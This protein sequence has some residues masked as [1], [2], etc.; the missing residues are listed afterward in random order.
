MMRVLWCA[1]PGGSGLATHVSQASEAGSIGVQHADGAPG[2][3]NLN[4]GPEAAPRTRAGAISSR[5]AA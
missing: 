5:R 1:L 2:P 4:D 3:G